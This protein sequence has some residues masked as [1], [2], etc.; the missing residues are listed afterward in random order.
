MP[1]PPS[2]PSHFDRLPTEL[3]KHIVF[4]VAVQDKEFRRA[5]V[6]RSSTRP[7]TK[8]I[9]Y[10]DVDESEVEQV[11]AEPGTFS[12]WYGRGV[13]ALSL[14]NKRLRELCL[15]LLLPIAK[16]AHFGSPF[17]IFGRVP[18]AILDG[19]QRID[20]RD[21]SESDFVATAA[22]LPKL[23]RVGTLELFADSR[24]P[25]STQ[26]EY[27]QGASPAERP[28]RALAKDAFKRAS[29]QIRCLVLHESGYRNFDNTIISS[30]AQSDTLRR[31]EFR[32]FGQ[33]LFFAVDG[34]EGV[35]SRRRATSTN[36]GD[37]IRDD[38]WADAEQ[39]S[40]L[41]TFKAKT[42]TSSIFDFVQKTMPKLERLKVVFT[43]HYGSP[44]DEFA[45]SWML[46][47]LKSLHIRGSSQITAALAHLHLP[48]LEII[49][50]AIVRAEGGTIDCTKLFTAD[51]LLPQN[52][53][54]HF[55]V[56]TTLR[57]ENADAVDAWC[58]KRDVHLVRFSSNLF[59]HYSGS[60]S[61]RQDDETLEDQAQAIDAVL[62]WTVHHKQRLLDFKDA[63]GL[64]ELAELVK[65]LRE[66][67]FIEDM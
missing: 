25:I 9:L 54:M 58:D 13:H 20:L 36:F 55:T 49:K 24:L 52:V 41:R 32:E 6:R 28:A 33:T 39:F 46:P 11:R 1:A 57:V 18:Q 61:R 12:W 16:P 17:F 5:G 37:L 27:R 42:T 64:Q 3:L 31:L 34:V 21:S 63:D 45:A 15:P 56:D 59:H 40:S 22:A 53:V 14:L 50:I 7:L 26:Y 60:T 51:T 35:R 30:F 43:D 66:R 44:P 4:M 8:T 38:P 47:S 65:P 19:I 67:E 10:N 2:R 48:V 29:S 23:K 62:L